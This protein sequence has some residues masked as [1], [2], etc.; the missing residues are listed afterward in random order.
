M[1]FRSGSSSLCCTAAKVKAAV[2]PL[3]VLALV[4][5]FG[6]SI[7]NL[8]SAQIQNATRT[9]LLPG[10]FAYQPKPMP[11]LNWMPDPPHYINLRTQDQL[12]GVLATLVAPQG[13]HV[14]P[15][16]AINIVES[17]GDHVDIAN[18]AISVVSPRNVTSFGWLDIWQKYTLMLAI[19][20]VLMVATIGLAFVLML[21]YRRERRVRRQ[22]RDSQRR[23]ESIIDGTQAGTWEWNLQ[24]GELRLNERWAQIVG[25]Q[26]AEL[27][28]IS[29]QTWLR[30]VHPDDV[31][32]SEKLLKQH[33]A[34]EHSHYDF[35]ARMW[36]KDGYWVWV[37][38]RG[39][40]AT[41]TPDGKP[42]WMFGTHL[43]ITARRRAQAERDAWLTR[44]R[45]LSANV[46]G[47]LYQY[48]LDTE[49]NSSFPFA[50]DGIRDIYGFSADELLEDASAVFQ[51]IHR[52]DVQGVSTSIQQSARTLATW[53]HAYRVLHPS[54]GERWVEGTATPK[55]QPDG[56]ILWHGYLT[57][58]TE[59]KRA[60]DQ[61]RLA[62]S[63][64]D[65]S[66][67]GICITD[68]RHRFIDVNR[69]FVELTGYELDDVRG[70]F[71]ESVFV[72]KP[73]AATPSNAM[74]AGLE[75]EG[76]WRG[77]LWAKRDAGGFFPVELSEVEVY[78]E[79]NTVAHHVTVFSDI[80]ERKK[81]EKELS[82]MAHF[83]SLT[84]IPNR[85]LFAECLKHALDSARAQGERVAVCMMDLDHFKPVNDRYGHEAGDKVLIE[86]A[87]RLERV[88]KSGDTVARLGG[89]EYALV[90]CHSED[91]SI[92]DRILDAVRE[93]IVLA[94]GQA[95]VSGS[96]GVAYFEPDRP[97]DGDL[98]M[99]QADQAAYESKS[100]G[101]DRV[102]VYEP[103]SVEH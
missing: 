2:T 39:R 44:F 33:V 53:R 80:S 31:N 42:E 88:V 77:E 91:E 37:H 9:E 95:C 61:L 21:I 66:R 90:I 71:S 73:D 27:E 76:R 36:H 3:M 41:R 14:V 67:E 8:A 56:A 81:Y 12:S 83:D 11:A 4:W 32:V 55:L 13:G 1:R 49:G 22:S 18:A 101:R 20:A 102:T 54:Y 68:R 26:L 43:D 86:V 48:R 57:D 98:L 69:A 84:G 79:K 63:V 72:E 24:T 93:P 25:Y 6:S 17:G 45:E 60:R 99:R 103:E 52:D 65:A 94:Q 47:G 70:A 62:A 29:I 46:P 15:L 59:L 89:D 51:R 34:D 97:Q 40:L 16:D 28:P 96:L 85:R 64:Y 19:L 30:L 5:V 82:E 75:R 10:M 38:D 100:A 74:M 7:F 50:S 23:L 78:D 58:I 35:E 92:F 87:R